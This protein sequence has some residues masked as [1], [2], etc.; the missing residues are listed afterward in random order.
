MPIITLSKLISETAV[1]TSQGL[2]HASQGVGK[3]KYVQSSQYLIVKLAAGPQPW[4][5]LRWCT[6][7]F[8]LPSHCQA[9]SF[10]PNWKQRRK[11]IAVEWAGRALGCWSW[12]HCANASPELSMRPR[13]VVGGEE[14]ERG[15]CHMALMSLPA[16]SAGR[17]SPFSLPPPC[18][19][20]VAT[21]PNIPTIFGYGSGLWQSK[22]KCKLQHTGLLQPT[23]EYCSGS[24]SEQQNNAYLSQ[25][26]FKKPQEISVR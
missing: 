4:G 20:A 14:R 1:Y 16:S 6:H 25:Q 3:L 2:L 11:S 23:L 24:F 19:V 26:H 5:P 9:T 12:P 18:I 7:N 10:H 15:A 22:I 21:P 13:V 8:V 17:T